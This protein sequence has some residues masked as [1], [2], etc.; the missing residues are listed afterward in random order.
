MSYTNGLTGWGGETY[1]TMKADFVF[2]NGSFYTLGHMVGSP[3]PSAIISAQERLWHGQPVPL[4]I[5]VGFCA[6]FLLGALV[7]RLEMRQRS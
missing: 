3:L 4:W 6:G 5:L 7:T 2:S 1:A